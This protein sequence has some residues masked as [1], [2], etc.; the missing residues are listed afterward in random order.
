MS[1]L[2]ASSTTETLDGKHVFDFFAVSR[3]LRNMD[4]SELMHD[5]YLAPTEAHDEL[6]QIV[7]LKNAALPPLLS[8]C[9][10]F[11]TEYEEEVLRST[12]CQLVTLAPSDGSSLAPLAHPLLSGSH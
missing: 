9:R 6:K 10:Q 1:S 11:G 2:D 12:V 3:E 7:Y 4:Y 5:V 8:I